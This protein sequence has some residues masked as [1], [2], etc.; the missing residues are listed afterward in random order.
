MTPLSE[1]EAIDLVRTAFA[2]ATER[3]IYTVSLCSS[4]FILFSLANPK[5]LCATRYLPK[6][7]FAISFT[8]VGE[9]TCK[10]RIL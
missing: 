2:S 6:S 9:D 7:E 5:F 4:L 8:L 10:W 3:D 1:S